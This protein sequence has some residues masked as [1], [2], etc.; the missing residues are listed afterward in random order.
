M[1]HSNLEDGINDS[2]RRA[3]ANEPVSGSLLESALA[4]AIANADKLESG[5]QLTWAPS[6]VR[7]PTIASMV[8]AAEEAETTDE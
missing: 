7:V 4:D 6:G 8:R 1:E 3:E 2:L 5:M